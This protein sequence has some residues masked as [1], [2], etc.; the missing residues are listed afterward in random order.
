MTAKKTPNIVRGC[1]ASSIAFVLML[2]GVALYGFIFPS[3]YRSNFKANPKDAQDTVQALAYSLAYNQL[4]GMKS[5]VS[6]DKWAFI[7]TWLTRHQALSPDCKAPEDSDVGPM[8]ASSFDEGTQVASITFFLNQRCPD[9]FYTFRISDTKLKR[10][11]GKWQVM[12]WLEI[13]E[14]T[15]EEKCY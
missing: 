4:D 6:P 3:P 11:D 5:Y 2:L 14:G 9:S 8:W 13:C 15:A 12:D 10:V 1:L 7:D